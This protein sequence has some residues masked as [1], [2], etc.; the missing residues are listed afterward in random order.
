MEQIDLKLNSSKDEDDEYTSR[1]HNISIDDLEDNDIQV[2]IQNISS[3]SP[4]SI[5]TSTHNSSELHS[6][7]KEDSFSDHD[8]EDDDDINGNKKFDDEV[9]TKEISAPYE[10][11]HFPIE[12]AEH[13]RQVQQQLSDFALKELEEK[14]IYLEDVQSQTTNSENNSHSVVTRIVSQASS[15][16]LNSESFQNNSNNNIVSGTAA[17]AAVLVNQQLQFNQSKQPLPPGQAAQRWPH[18]DS[19]LLSPE[20]TNVTGVA[21]EIDYLPHF[22]RI[23]STGDDKSGVSNK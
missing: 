10:V 16:N 11:P 14:A 15:I 20:S 21:D 8:D 7:R 2:R 6:S 22:Q 23:Y 13:R 19:N 3:D 4:L 12:L 5:V 17:V 9:K 18:E 1:F